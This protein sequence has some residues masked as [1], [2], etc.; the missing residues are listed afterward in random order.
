VPE[1]TTTTARIEVADATE[2]DDPSAR[3]RAREGGGGPKDRWRSWAPDALTVAALAVAAFIA[4]RDTLPTN[5]LWHDDAWVAYGAAEGSLSRLFTVGADHP[6]FT[7]VLMGWTRLG[8]DFESMSYLA[9]IAGTLGPPSLYF[10]LRHLGVERSISTVLGATL[11]AANIHIMYSGRV[12]TYTL[13]VLIVLGLVVAIA[14]LAGTKWR[15]HTAVAWVAAATVVGSVSAFALVA[16]AAA[17]LI[18]LLHPAS[19]GRVRFVAVSVQA[20][21]QLILFAAMQRTYDSHELEAWWARMH[22]A[23]LDFD[24]NP[25]RFGAELIEHLSR[26]AHVFPGGSGWWATLSVIVALL[27]LLGAGLTRRSHSTAVRAR[28]L[29][30]ILLVAVVGAVQDKFPFGPARGGGDIFPATYSRG[31][32]A[33]LWLIPL[34]AVGLAITLQALRG[35]AVRRQWVRVAFDTVTYIVA[36]IVVVTALGNDAPPYALPGSESAVE[37]VKS[38]LGENDSLLVIQGGHYQLALESGFDASIQARPQESI[39]FVPQFADPRVHIVDFDSDRN[40]SRH[41]REAVQGVD[42]VLVYSGSHI[43][44]FKFAAT[45]DPVLRSEGFRMR[46]TFNFG[47]EKVW[48]WQRS[49]DQAAAP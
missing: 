15:W 32:R 44:T 16:T 23:Y 45:Q 28:Y 17:G 29:L 9:L 41:T 34:V 5:G 39:G 13:D 6:A 18:L 27:G 30:V 4:R 3:T 37:F 38:E 40:M 47:A 26:V 1:A 21:L 10:V 36:A 49:L 12:K 20:I 42:R 8:G 25:V 31:E 22:D 48:I 46:A 2:L 35:F 11:V 24:I 14:A 43:F 33:T 19:D 7:L